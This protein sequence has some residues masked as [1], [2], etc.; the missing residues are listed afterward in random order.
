MMFR[1]T[2]YIV[3]WLYAHPPTKQDRKGPDDAD[4]QHAPMPQMRVGKLDPPNPMPKLPSRT[5]ISAAAQRSLPRQRENM[6]DRIPSDRLDDLEKRV[7][8]LEQNA[9]LADQVFLE[10]HKALA[11]IGSG[12]DPADVVRRVA[13][14][15]AAT[16]ERPPHE[17]GP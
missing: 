3:I 15:A 1:D 7:L 2:S 17:E 16:Q 14:A 8:D 13:A 6:K 9:Q 12:A 4:A 10:I 5:R 11:A